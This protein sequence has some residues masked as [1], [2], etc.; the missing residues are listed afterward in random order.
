MEKDIERVILS[1]EKIS[2]R[3]DQLG[4]EITKDLSCLVRDDDHE[5]LMLPILHGSMIFA[6]DLMRQ[7]PLKIRICTVS[8]SSYPGPATTSQGPQIIGGIPEEVAGRHVLIVDD[9]LDSGRTLKLIRES[10]LEGGAKTVRTCVLLRKKIP[11]AMETPCEYVGFDIQ[12]EFVV[13]YGLDYD[14]YYRNLPEIVVLR[15]DDQR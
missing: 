3:V 6:A 12:N 10:V 7:I 13:G 8:M 9:I 14:N 1:R 4:D 11:S 2:T 15:S 5:L